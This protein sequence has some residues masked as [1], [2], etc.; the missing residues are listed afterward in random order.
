MKQCWGT[1]AKR[2]FVGIRIY[3]IHVGHMISTHILRS[4]FQDVTTLQA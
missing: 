2:D 3:T 4:Q 1:A